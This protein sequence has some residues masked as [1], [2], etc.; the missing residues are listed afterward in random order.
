MPKAQASKY[1]DPEMPVLFTVAKP[2]YKRAESA[3]SKRA[4]APIYYLFD[5]CLRPQVKG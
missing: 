1:G 2:A 5:S 4:D 3:K